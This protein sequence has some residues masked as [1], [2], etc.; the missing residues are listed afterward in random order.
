MPPAFAQFDEPHAW[1]IRGLIEYGWPDVSRAGGHLPQGV[2]GGLDLNTLIETEGRDG[3]V[4]E[5]AAA[6]GGQVC[7]D[8]RYRFTVQVADTQHGPG[9]A[10]RCPEANF[11]QEFP[12]NAD[13]PQ[14]AAGYIHQ[15]LTTYVPQFVAWRLQG[16]EVSWAERVGL[17]TVA[18]H[19]CSFLLARFV[20]DKVG[21]NQRLDQ[22]P[23][24]GWWL[25]GAT[26]TSGPR[27][28][29]VPPGDGLL[30]MG[31]GGLIQT[32]KGGGD[33]TYLSA[34]AREAAARGESIASE[35]NLQALAR[36]AAPGWA[37]LVM[38]GVGVFQ[39]FLWFVN[40]INVVLYY[41]DDSIFAL[42]FSLVACIGLF[43]ASAIAGYGAWQYRKL[44]KGP[45]PWVAIV[46]AALVPGCCV[47]GLPIAIWAGMVWRDPMVTR[48]RGG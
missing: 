38:A 16:G 21:S 47:A 32:G 35:G 42:A 25:D 19:P 28:A 15:A 11:L 34:A 9:F 41:L 29:V 39:A 13:N 37:L 12:Y 40:A 31:G 44:A 30:P 36:V 18:G 20:A 43:L 22:G 3:L 48:A 17:P 5:M 7:E 10:V 6:S 27:P 1:L 24:Q 26:R 46:Y 45:L 33:P 8:Q 23:Q 4:L 14:W 2:P